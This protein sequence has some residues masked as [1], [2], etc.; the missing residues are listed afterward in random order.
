MVAFAPQIDVFFTYNNGKVRHTGSIAFSI[1]L[2]V[3]K[4]KFDEECYPDNTLKKL[5][6]KKDPLHDWSVCQQEQK[7]NLNKTNA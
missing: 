5:N 2:I 6:Y 3:C 4:K 1:V 7:I